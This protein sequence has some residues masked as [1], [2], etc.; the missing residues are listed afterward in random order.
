MLLFFV[1]MVRLRYDPAPLDLEKELT[2]LLKHIWNYNTHCDRNDYIDCI[3]YDYD[4]LD[5]K[6]T[7]P[8][9]FEK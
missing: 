4:S 3:F 1:D 9:F 2:A 8:G 6:R 7:V 5:L